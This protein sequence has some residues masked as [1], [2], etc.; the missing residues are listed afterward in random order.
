MILSLL[1]RS[2]LSPCPKAYLE[3]KIV[4]ER[5]PKA[6]FCDF[7]E[8]PPGNPWSSMIAVPVDPESREVKSQSGARNGSLGSF[9]KASGLR[10]EVSLEELLRLAE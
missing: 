2:K 7:S 3:R 10:A 9:T 5:H 6:W 1:F 8:Q 4:H